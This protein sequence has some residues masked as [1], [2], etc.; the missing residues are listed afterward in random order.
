MYFNR[1]F[2]LCY[3]VNFLGCVALCCAVGVS[4]VEV[5]E[6]RCS[7]ACG[8]LVPWP[9]IKFM[10][11]ALK[12][13]YF[14]YWTARDISCYKILDSLGSPLVRTLH[15]HRMYGVCKSL[16]HLWLF[17]TPQTVARQALLSMGFSRQ[18]YW[19]GIAIPFS[20][21]SSWPRDGTPGLLHCRQ[22]LYHLSHREDLY[23]R[24]QK[25]SPWSGN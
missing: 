9:S 10:S 5:H 21:R 15:F 22:I 24:R 17:A 25:F 23:C 12:G 4:L 3:F 1:L 11:P 2:A 7:T 18:E 6:L 16:S 13:G 20:R 14:Y 19:S 8:I